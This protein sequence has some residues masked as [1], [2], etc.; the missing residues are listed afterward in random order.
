MVSETTPVNIKGEQNDAFGKR[1][2]IE[3]ERLQFK[4]VEICI[5]TGVSKTT[6]IKYESS[7]RTPDLAY[8]A[9]LE[10]LGFDLMF[11]V[12]GERSDA[13]PMNPEYQNLLEAYKAAPEVLRRSAFA[14]LL[15]PYISEWDK[16]RV[17]PGY[18]EHEI[19]GEENARFAAHHAATRTTKV[20]KAP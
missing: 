5:R 4:Q 19:L 15:S 12:T 13:A 1:I 18:F 17:V 16:S 8:L 9:D 6:Q 2:V 14:V 11:I 7:E 3:R 10:R 20:K